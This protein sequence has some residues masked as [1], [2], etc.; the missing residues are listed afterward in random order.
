MFQPQ[1]W[2][3]PAGEDVGVRETPRTSPVR[4]NENDSRPGKII[5]KNGVFQL[6][7]NEL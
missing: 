5:Y 4:E 6:I 1:Q 7:S 2:G 3:G